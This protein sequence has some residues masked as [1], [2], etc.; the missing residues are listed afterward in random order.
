MIFFAHF[1]VQMYDIW[2]IERHCFYILI[3]QNAS[4]NTRHKKLP[5]SLEYH[6][7]IREHDMYE[8]MALS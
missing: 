2:V 6:V 1:Q 3:S 4:M 7:Y 8:N 5:L